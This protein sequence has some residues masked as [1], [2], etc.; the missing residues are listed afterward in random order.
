M[1]R[2]AEVAGDDYV[3]RCQKRRDKEALDSRSCLVMRLLS[4]DRGDCNERR[5]F[6]TRNIS[7]CRRLC[8]GDLWCLERCSLGRGRGEGGGLPGE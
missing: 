1:D 7:H 2:G 4:L 6:T 3:G 5:G 8:K